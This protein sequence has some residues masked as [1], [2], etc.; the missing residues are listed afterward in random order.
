M[1]YFHLY[2][3]V[4]IMAVYLT[5]FPFSF[6][7]GIWRNFVSCIC[8]WVDIAC[9]NNIVCLLVTFAYPGPSLTAIPRYSVS[10]QVR[11]LGDKETTTCYS[12]AYVDCEPGI[13]IHVSGLGLG[14]WGLWGL[15]GVRNADIWCKYDRQS[16]SCFCAHHFDTSCDLWQHISDSETKDDPSWRHCGQLQHHPTFN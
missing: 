11:N 4:I 7:L 1:E 2:F 12:G 16:A 9:G 10:I 14:G 6:D 15:W 13:W 3:A 5:Q 8:G